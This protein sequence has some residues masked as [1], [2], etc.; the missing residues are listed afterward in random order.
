MLS[1]IEAV[2]FRVLDVKG[3]VGLNR[4]IDVH[5]FSLKT[6]LVLGALLIGLLPL[7]IAALVIPSRISKVIEATN[8]E[9]LQSTAAGLAEL[10]QR[11]LADNLAM[12]SSHAG[13][14][15]YAEA[16]KA[17]EEGRLTQQM[18]DDVNL[19][20]GKALA[21][22][23]PNYQGLFISDRNGR[24]FAGV[25]KGGDASLYRDVDIHDR[26]YF[27]AMLE[28]PQPII[29]DPAKSKVGNVPIVVLSAPIIDKDGKFQGLL[30]LSMEID[31]LSKIIGSTHK[32]DGSYGF[33]IDRRGIMVAH[34]DP[35]RVLVLEFSKV[36]GAEALSAAMIRG[37]AGVQSYVSSTGVPKMAGYAPVPISG[38]SV[39]MSV[40]QASFLS[41]ERHARNLIFILA[42]LCSLIA[43]VGA[44][45][46]GVSLSRPLHA[47]IAGLTEASTSM[48]HGS[49]EIS[50]A[51]NSLAKTTSEQA[52]SIEET[53]AAL[54][55][56]SSSTV[57]N[58]EN[59]AKAAELAERAGQ[60]IQ[61]ADTRMSG[62]LGAV[63]QA[64]QESIQTRQ[65]IKNIDDIA[66]QTNI[67]ALNAA[68][69]AARAGE[70]GAG[71][72]V[73]AEEVR[74]LAGRAAAAAKESGSTL[75][76]IES[77]VAQSKKLAE[78]V[79]A[80]FA[81]VRTEA[82][83][84]GSLVGEIASS[85]REEAKAIREVSNSLSSIEQGVQSGAAMAEESAASAM[86][87]SKQ[88]TT[89]RENT[90]GLHAMLNGVSKS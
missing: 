24:V 8:S 46:L 82:R 80:E 57:T 53:S 74:S 15:L 51:S 76:K 47:A 3:L 73:V 7:L 23:G 52:A 88:A 9:N 54:T 89:V 79:G 27:K 4:L 68:V 12:V 67:L 69:E 38:W 34:P 6:K 71:F 31:F 39:A 62:L 29:G 84:V 49:A 86:E 41:A 58:A 2:G 35:A 26:A 59:A 61:G 14:G 45:V 66:F 11:A 43:V 10:T 19:Y 78:E 55:E 25:G 65:V 44:F 50:N 32:S 1:P 85:C 30:G 72:A 70:A 81:G 75:E 42:G 16:L 37:D 22:Q 48:D 56:I 36:K 5:S 40:D 33:A 13:Y 83:E 87:I 64:A 63:K 28:K 20:I 17:R 60:R 90:E 18:I 21:A 77:L